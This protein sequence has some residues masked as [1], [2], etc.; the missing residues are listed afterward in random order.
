M[1]LFN[2]FRLFTH[3]IPKTIAATSFHFFFK[4]KSFPVCLSSVYPECAQSVKGCIHLQLIATCLDRKQ[5]QV[6]LVLG[7]NDQR[8]CGLIF[9]FFFGL[10]D[11]APDFGSG[12]CRF[13]SCHGRF[14]L[15]S[16]LT[17][18]SCCGEGIGLSSRSTAARSQCTSGPNKDIMS[19]SPFDCSSDA[20]LHDLDSSS[21]E[22]LCYSLTESG[23]LTFPLHV[24]IYDIYFT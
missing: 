2:V 18:K 9:F 6:W 19:S 1:C 8:P 22:K 12:D 24:K 7:G 4:T 20:A 21:K 17:R 10:M 15:Q 13:E 11:K 5:S 14:L 3:N 23:V 16:R